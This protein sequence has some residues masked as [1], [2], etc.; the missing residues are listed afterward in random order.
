MEITIKILELDALVNALNN[1]ASALG[2]KNIQQTNNQP[3]QSTQ[4]AP[5]QN[6]PTYQQPVQQAPAQT[7]TYQQ[8]IQ[9][10]APVN[11]PNQSFTQQQIPNTQ[12]PIQQVPTSHG[13]QNY[14][15]DQLAVAM[16]ALHD[17]GKLD[18]VMGALS[19]FG[20]ETLMQVPKEQYAAL[21]TMLRG[22]GANI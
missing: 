12:A 9:Q 7:P 19:Q 14:T 16:T 20:A 6:I 2:G 10:T 5:V 11:A 13:T 22:A 21:A 17:A 1:L 3:V 4:Q 18:A 8:P 15:Q